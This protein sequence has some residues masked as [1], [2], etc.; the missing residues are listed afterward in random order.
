MFV[1]NSRTE[2]NRDHREGT[3]TRCRWAG[4]FVRLHQAHPLRVTCLDETTSR[5]AGA[6]SQD[7][8]LGARRAS[9]ARSRGDRSRDRVEVGLDLGEVHPEQAGAKVVGVDVAGLD[10]PAKVIGWT[11]KCSAAAGMSTRCLLDFEAVVFIAVPSETKKAE[12]RQTPVGQ[13]AAR[14]CAVSV[15]YCVSAALRSR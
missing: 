6:W 2:I 8:A 9:E 7:R 5:G 12:E 11:L 3:L 1:T 15:R 10:P 14:H 13:I 4:T